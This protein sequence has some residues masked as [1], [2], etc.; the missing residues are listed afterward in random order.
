MLKYL[1]LALL[2]LGILCVNG[3][4]APKAYTILTE[5]APPTNYLTP[6]EELVGSSTEIVREILQRIHWQN[7][8]ITV[9]P[10]ARAYTM[11]LKGPRVVLFS[12]TRT[13][14]RERL[15]KWVGPIFTQR[16]V[17]YK[18]A[19]SPLEINTLNDA[20]EVAAIGTYYN[21]VAEQYLKQQGFTNLE[22]VPDDQLNIH[23]LL[24]G[25]LQLWATGD[26]AIDS[27]L[28]TAGYSVADIKEAFVLQSIQLYIA[29]SPG[30]PDDIINLWQTALDEIKAEGLY[31]RILKEYTSLPPQ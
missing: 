1:P 8:T 16:Q 20:K 23:K 10:W 24:R 25:R 22:S 4:A 2:I 5:N 6:Q 29:F 21:D 31:H 13:K 12:T 7:H 15:F 11:A 27:R 30:T 18:A 19:S 28:H 17:L 3:Q 9:L 14:E 26:A